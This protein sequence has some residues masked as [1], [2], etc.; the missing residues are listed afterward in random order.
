[1]TIR[2]LTEQEFVDP[3][4]G[5]NCIGCSPRNL[6]GLQLK[7]V[8]QGDEVHAEFTL[9]RD[10]ESYPGMIHGGV[11]ALVLDEVIGRA[12][13]WRARRLVVTMGIRIRYAS[14]MKP[15]TPY[16]CRAEV[17]PAKGEQLKGTGSIEGLDGSL[18][19]IGNAT[20]A[21]LSEQQLQD[22]AL[23]MPSALMDHLAQLDVVLGGP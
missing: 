4:F 23:A 7:F 13:L 16:R 20:F 2:P 1:M 10:Y 3:S 19:A 9:S 12:A 15:D 8:P 21:H 14:L 5:A 18:V 11:V 6:K 22:P 17:E